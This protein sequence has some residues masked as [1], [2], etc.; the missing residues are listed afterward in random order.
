MDKA[1]LHQILRITSI[2]LLGWFA[3]PVYTAQ[4][5]DGQLLTVSVP[6]P[7]LEN[8]L[9]GFPTSRETAIYLP[10]SYASSPEKSYPVL[11]VLH[12]IT[13]PITVWTEPWHP[14]EVQ[15]GT[16]PHLMDHGI[17]TG[18]ISEMILVIPDA[19]TPFFGCHYTNS[20][21]K[22]NWQDFITKDLLEFV[23]ANY[24][25]MRIAA[26]RGI[27]GHS[28]G[29]HGA[30]KIGMQ[31]PD[32][33]SAVYGMNPSL[34]GWGGDVAAD[35]PAFDILLSSEDPSPHFESNFYVPAI[36]GVSQAF[37]PNPDNPP[38]FADYPF[39]KENGEIVPNHK[40]FAQ[41]EANF[42]TSLIETYKN[43]PTKLRGLRFDSA[44][45]DEFSHIP[46]TNRTFSEALSAQG[47]THTFEMYNGDHRNRLW[48][49]QGRLYTE[50]LPYFSA[51]LD[52]ARTI[53][54]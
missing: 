26:G 47:V 7:S 30:I 53:S 15:F 17:A 32:L 40:A 8:N 16:L 13:D 41:W 28:M 45:T 2:M 51:L 39:K 50:A 43:G 11:I 22:G 14:D 9:L 5:Q 29:G 34:M 21:V 25:T 31:H 1:N 36:I 52:Q 49:K 4:A 23:D 54:D 35:N 3:S 44:F 27:M 19:R 48:G 46:P 42:P 33:F 18:L 38:F 6:G 20:S 10:P 37:S 24:R 12:G